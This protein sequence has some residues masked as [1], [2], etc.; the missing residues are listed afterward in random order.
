MTARVLCIRWTPNDRDGA[1]RGRALAARLTQEAWKK[2]CDWRGVMLFAHVD[3]LA[4]VII[5][6][7]E[8]GVIVGPLFER[9]K[10]D[11]VQSIASDEAETLVTTGGA[12]LFGK[13]WGP[14][15][16]LLHNR[17]Y[18]Y[19]H[20]VRDPAGGAPLFMHEADQVQVFF[21]DLEDF[22]AI[23]D[24]ELEC[25]HDMV[26]AYMVQPRLLTCRTAIKNVEELLA[27]ERLSFGR[28]T[29]KRDLIWRPVAENKFEVADFDVAAQTLRTAVVASASSW[30][31]F[32]AAQGAQPIVHRLSG[33]LDS[34]IVLAALRANDA[35]PASVICFNE[36]PEKTP[37]GDERCLA[38]LA[39]DHFG[40]AL[41]EHE[42]R[43][44]AFSYNRLL[45]APLPVRPTHTEL[46]HAAP[47]L[48]AAINAL[49]AR[50]VTSGQ[51]GDQ[52]LHRR[53]FAASAVD[54]AL[55]RVGPSEWFRI[56]R[57][58]A[59]LSRVPIWDTVSETIAHVCGRRASLFNPLFARTL[60]GAKDAVAIATEE[61]R[62]HPW[63]DVFARHP[64]AR[65]ARAMHIGDLSYYHEPSAVTRA[66][67]TAPVIAS[68]P[69]VET[70]LSMPPYLM[71]LGG[72]D[73][74]LARA[75]F[76][77]DLPD[78]IRTRS[79]KGDT[80]RFHNR[81]LERQ[82]PLMRE[83]LLDG[84]LVKRCLVDRARLEAVLGRDVIADGSLKGA[85]MSAFVAEAWLRRF[86]ARLSSKAAMPVQG[87]SAA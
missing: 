81:V 58:T 49:G 80:T 20:A 63:A 7:A 25:D 38:R 61:W 71:T 6:P 43:A 32:N 62:L 18:D 78:D 52:V 1:R 9:G 2:L 44:D 64:P 47:E 53:R 65:A 57:D 5:L 41:V 68:L 70:V 72:F 40:Y 17:G 54:A 76:A 31:A 87:E 83:I 11:P 42:S 79:H 34:S 50:L 33:G 39:A 36:F 16:A 4:G 67:T 66:F 12:H 48:A 85:L 82:L 30:I 75:A 69:V 22:I 27:G 55:D 37:E 21:T 26:S 29:W 51:G 59:R 60:L 86:T 28:D 15:C 8:F 3:T 14:C 74:S 13:Y 77:N 10:A 23:W 35:D 46:S 73:R 45:D 56:A 19:F 84:E 24:G